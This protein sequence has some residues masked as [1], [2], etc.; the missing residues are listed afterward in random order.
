MERIFLVSLCH[1]NVE[2]SV[3]RPGLLV[4]LMFL[5]FGLLFKI[6]VLG[7]NISMVTPVPLPSLKKKR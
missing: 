5:G 7:W 3:G 1:G 6:C 2:F 4:S